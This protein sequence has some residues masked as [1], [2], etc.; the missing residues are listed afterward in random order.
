[1]RFLILKNHV[2][3]TRKIKDWCYL[4]I[5]TLS[6]TNYCFECKYI[7]EIQCINK[8]LRDLFAEEEEIYLNKLHNDE[9]I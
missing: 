3:D 1:M 2:I 9:T 7:W 4:D 6:E 8:K 5:D